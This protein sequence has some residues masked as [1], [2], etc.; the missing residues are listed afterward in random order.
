M[1]SIKGKHTKPEKVMR[2]LLR[3]SG[4]KFSI[5][6]EL[7]GHPDIVIKAKRLA[8]FIDGDFWHGWHYLQRRKALSS[9]WRNKLEVNIR[10]DKKQRLALRKMGWRVIR[11]WEHEITATPLKSLKKIS[12]ALNTRYYKL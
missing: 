5:Y 12:R 11:I 9:F 10:R 8:V 2:K 1:S 7:P 4:I 3:S 6:S